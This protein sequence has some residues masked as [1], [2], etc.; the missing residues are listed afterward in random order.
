MA[1]AELQVRE[2]PGDRARDHDAGH[3][4]VGRRNALQ[5]VE[6]EALRRYRAPVADHPH[7]ETRNDEEH[8][9]ARRADGEMATGALGRVE[10]HD[11]KRRKGTQ[12]LDPVEGLHAV[13]S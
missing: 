5:A 2:E 6:Q 1:G 3:Q 11:R 10:H 8:V 4:P 9:D 13:S 12:I 7:D